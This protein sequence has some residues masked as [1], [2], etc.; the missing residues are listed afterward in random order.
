M[1]QSLFQVLYVYFLIFQHEKELSNAL[2]PWLSYV[3]QPVLEKKHWSEI[4]TH[5]EQ[6]KENIKASVL[7]PL[8]EHRCVQRVHSHKVNVFFTILPKLSFFGGWG[9]I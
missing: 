3:P 2:T 9:V 6:V 8:V 1:F 4:E 7:L 5:K